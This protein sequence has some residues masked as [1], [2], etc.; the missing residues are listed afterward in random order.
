MFLQIYLLSLW[1]CESFHQ[2]KS[3]LS[4]HGYLHIKDINF[5]YI[6]FSAESDKK[7]KFYGRAIFFIYHKTNSYHTSNSIYY[8]FHLMI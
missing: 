1:L 5:C 2:S 7:A 3:Y 4:Y 8:S 6:K